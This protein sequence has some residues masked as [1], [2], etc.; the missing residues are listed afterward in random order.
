MKQTILESRNLKKV[1]DSDTIPTVALDGVSAEFCQGE[2]TIIMGA[3]GSGKS[4]LLYNVSG[5]DKPTDGDV[6][7]NGTSIGALKEKPLANLRRKDFGFV[8][9]YMTLIENLTVLENMLIPGFLVEKNR[10]KVLQRADELLKM[11]GLAEKTNRYPTQLSGGEQQRA[12]IARAL[13]NSPQILFADEP[14]GTL[15]HQMSQNLLTH[16]YQLKK[17][18]QTIIMVTHDIKSAAWGDRIL[19]L[20]D[21]RIEGEFRFGKIEDPGKYLA[22]R[23]KELFGWLSGLG[24]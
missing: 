3:S 9:Q 7:F 15:N 14:T 23:E 19:Y 22:A 8:F 24:W 1:F 5:L 18:G 6:I 4:T 12:S 21:G 20:K 2:F 13:I 17:A 11:L 10:S 16:L